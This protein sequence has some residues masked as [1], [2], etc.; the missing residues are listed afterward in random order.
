MF[1][2]DQWRTGFQRL[3]IGATPLDDEALLGS[4]RAQQLRMLAKHGPLTLPVPLLSAF[5]LAW[6]LWDKC[7]GFLAPWLLLH[8]LLFALCAARARSNIHIKAAS[9]WNVRIGS[10]TALSMACLW[11]ALPVVTMAQAEA[12]Q[13]IPILLTMAALSSAGAIVLQTLPLAATAWVILLVACTVGAMWQQGL[14]YAP[15][16]GVVAVF[17][18]AILIRNVF[19]SSHYLFSRTKLAHEAHMLSQ[20]LA[21]Q[22]QVAQGTANGVLVLDS[23]G[24]IV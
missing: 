20:S 14:A 1:R 4:Y 10:L 9:S 6:M 2:L 3:P 11:G 18:G 13:Q 21:L 16:I 8:V 7:S 23:H 12:S 22:A 15:Q 19:M 17:F 24:A 5:S